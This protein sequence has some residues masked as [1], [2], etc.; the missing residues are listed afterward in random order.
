MLF[1]KPKQ[2]SDL[3][4]KQPSL[5]TKESQDDK[6]NKLL[7][8][9]IAAVNTTKDLV[10][11]ALAKDILGTIAN[12]LTIAQSVIKNKSDFLAIVDKCEAIRRVLTRAI[13]DATPENL[14]GPLGGALSELHM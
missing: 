3:D 1:K 14:R 5:E 9:T 10:P 11:I 8:I 13:K 6:V 2:R 7:G 4:I 12:I